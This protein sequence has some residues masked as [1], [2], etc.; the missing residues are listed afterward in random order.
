M[1]TYRGHTRMDSLNLLPFGLVPPPGSMAYLL[2]PHPQSHN[3][4]T[5]MNERVSLF[6]A[7]GIELY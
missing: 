5:R 4:H 1:L 2:T 3:L 7:F 6:L